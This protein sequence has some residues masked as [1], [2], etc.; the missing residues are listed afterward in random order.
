MGDA[1][2]PEV[3]LASAVGL[4]DGTHRA[5]SSVP[6]GPPG[7]PGVRRAGPGRGRS[8]SSPCRWAPRGSR[9]PRRRGSPPCRPAPAPP[10]GRA[11]SSSSAASTRPRRSPATD[12]RL[13]PGPAAGRG[14]AS[15]APRAAG[16]S[17]S[18]GSGSAART[19]R[20]RNRSRQALTTIR[21]SQV[22]TAA[23]PRKDSARRNA[24][25]SASWRAS[26]ASSGLPVVRRATAQS[27]S[28]WRREQL[29]ERVGVAGEVCLEQGG[30]VAL[31]AGAIGR[32]RRQASRPDRDVGD[33]ARGSRRRPRAA[34]SARR[35]GSA[36][37]GVGSSLTVARSGAAVLAADLVE[38]VDGV[39]GLGHARRGGVHLEGGGRRP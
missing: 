17:R 34:W 23:S 29:A 24:E 20:R 36:S 26:A 21:C 7:P 3:D 14:P 4:P 27:R 22:V 8:G 1:G 5:G 28:R 9:P 35:A 30:V 16:S 38:L 2:W 33:L 10:S 13:G 19:L 15:T 12:V 37:S 31:P 11:G 39:R 18:S 6:G 32:R 25:I